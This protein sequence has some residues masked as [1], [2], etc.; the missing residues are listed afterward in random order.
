[1]L[2][3]LGIITEATNQGDFQSILVKKEESKGLF[4]KVGTG[5]GE[6]GLNPLNLG[7][8]EPSKVNRDPSQIVYIFTHLNEQ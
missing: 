8:D 2:N 3:Q 5:I 6:I 7:Q 1:M 4:S